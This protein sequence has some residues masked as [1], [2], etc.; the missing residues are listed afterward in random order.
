MEWRIVVAN[1]ITLE[2]LSTFQNLLKQ[3]E[4]TEVETRLVQSSLVDE[5]TGM[6]KGQNPI[7][8]VKGIK[9]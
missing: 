3:Y 8:I 4:Y 9:R 7:F 6:L 5:K 1:F 2:N